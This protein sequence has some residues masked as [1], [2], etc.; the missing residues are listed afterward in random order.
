MRVCGFSGII[1]ILCLID[2]IGLDKPVIIPACLDFPDLRIH[3]YEAYFPPYREALCVRI[4]VMGSGIPDDFKTNDWRHA[5]SLAIQRLIQS[6]SRE[7]R[8]FNRG[9][10][11]NKSYRCKRRQTFP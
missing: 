8:C 6:D 10:K 2:H 11:N 1:I 4:S 9:K 3:L 7:Y 5:E